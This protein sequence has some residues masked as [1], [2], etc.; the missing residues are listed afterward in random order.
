MWAITSIQGYI[1]VLSYSSTLQ[2]N[3]LFQQHPKTGELSKLPSSSDTQI[4][5]VMMRSYPHCKCS[6]CPHTSSVISLPLI[7]SSIV[8]TLCLFSV[9]SF[10]SV[11]S[12]LSFT[13]LLTCLLFQS[14]LCLFISR[15]IRNSVGF[16][17]TVCHTTF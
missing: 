9:Y 2:S 16:S 5:P 4:P 12:P 15:E 8:I 17:P 6:H 7:L 11:I 13:L 10:L 14:C 1:F 3:M